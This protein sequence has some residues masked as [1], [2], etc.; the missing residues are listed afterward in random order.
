MIWCQTVNA[1][2][3]CGPR[4]GLQPKRLTAYVLPLCFLWSSIYR[5]VILDIE[6]HNGP[7]ITNICLSSHK[8]VIGEFWNFSNLFWDQIPDLMSQSQHCSD[9]M[10]NF[11]IRLVYDIYYIYSTDLFINSWLWCFS[12]SLWFQTIV[13]NINVLIS[14]CTNCSNCKSSLHCN[15]V[16]VTLNVDADNVL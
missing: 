14:D 15:K 11:Q 6:A 16:D 2:A 12:I 1:K 4:E 9:T 8:M 3:S 13:T 7:A 5:F 10:L